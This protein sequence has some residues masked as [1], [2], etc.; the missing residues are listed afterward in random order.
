MFADD[1]PGAGVIFSPVQE[2]IRDKRQGHRSTQTDNAYY[3]TVQKDWKKF[4]FAGEYFKMG[5]FYRPQ[6]M[7]YTLNFCLYLL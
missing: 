5:K 7:Y 6:I 1:V 2:Y 4:G 3:V